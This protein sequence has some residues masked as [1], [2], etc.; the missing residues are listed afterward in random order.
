M[1]RAL[2]FNYRDW[3]CLLPS[4]A[5]W[6]DGPFA[7]LSDSMGGRSTRKL[8]KRMKRT[9][10]PGRIRRGI[11]QAWSHQ[12]PQWHQALGWTMGD[13]AQSHAG[14]A[15]HREKL[16]SLRELAYGASHEINNPLTNISL[17]AQ[18]LL[19]AET[20]PKRRR[21]LKAINDQVFRAHEM[22]ADLMLFAKPPTLERQPVDPPRIID[23]VIEQ[24][25]QQSDDQSVRIVRSLTKSLPPLF[26][27]PTQLQVALAAICKNALEALD[28][29]GGQIRL[30]A[31]QTMQRGERW[32]LISVEDDGPGIPEGLRK[33]VFDPFFSGREAGRGLGFGLSKAWRIVTEHDGRLSLDTTE[34]GKTRFLVE[35]PSRTSASPVSL[36]D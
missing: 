19:R 11:Q 18:N 12:H 30:R 8:I 9:R 35:L 5:G 7:R 31:K 36:P 26:A 2:L 15:L 10:L 25:R 1:T 13:G 4:S 27:D 34:N 16:A 21:D 23:A 33:H 6:E 14:D 20:D 22:I 24:I 3:L 28:E 32:V 17:R 29:T